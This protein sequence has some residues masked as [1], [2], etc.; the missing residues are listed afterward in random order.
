[1][2]KTPVTLGSEDFPSKAAAKAYI[3]TEILNNYEVGVPID[4]DVHRSVLSGVLDLKDNRDEK[5]GAGIDYFY[6]AWKRDFAGDHPVTHDGKTIAIHRIS[7]DDVDFGYTNTIDG[8]SQAAFVREALRAEIGD[9]RAT[10]RS[11]QFRSGPV[12]DDAGYMIEKDSDAEVRYASPSWGD[13]TSAFAR[14]VG[15]WASIETNSGDGTPQVGRR[16]VSPDVRQRW[17]EFWTAEAHPTLRRK[18]R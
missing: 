10:Y 5:V 8:S 12:Y 15:G 6:V 17:R 11:S 9:L 18:F 16:L 14:S 4:L 13:L 7:G 3:S 2:T 1:M